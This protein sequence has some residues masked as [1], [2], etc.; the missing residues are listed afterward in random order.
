MVCL[1]LMTK[2]RRCSAGLSVGRARSTRCWITCTRWA[3]AVAGGAPR[4]TRPG[5]SVCA[6]DE[7]RWARGST[8]R[9]PACAGWTGI[10]DA[11]I[12]CCAVERNLQGHTDP[13]ELQVQHAHVDAVI[14]LY[15]PGYQ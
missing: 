9:R 2:P 7:R 5:N 1:Q 11:D 13:M 15:L 3:L 14:E 12:K 4:G 8:A 6:P 10:D